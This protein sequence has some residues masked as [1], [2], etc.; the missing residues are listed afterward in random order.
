MT[1]PLTKT[2]MTSN[3]GAEAASHDFSTGK[4]VTSSVVENSGFAPLGDN[5]SAIGQ[6]DQGADPSAVSEYRKSSSALKGNPMT[7]TTGKANSRQPILAGQGTALLSD[8]I[9]SQR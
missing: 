5:V 2:E 6:A 7:P 3:R 8:Y 1:R 4:R 9:Q